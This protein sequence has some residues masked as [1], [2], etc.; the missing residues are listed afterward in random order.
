[1]DNRMGATIGCE[2]KRTSRSAQL[3]VAVWTVAPERCTFSSRSSSDVTSAAANPRSTAS[4][5]VSVRSF[6]SSMTPSTS[7]DSST[8]ASASRG[9]IPRASARARNS[10]RMALTIFSEAF[11]P[12]P[13][14]G[15]AAPIDDTGPMNTES[16]ASAI[17]A[18][19]LHAWALTNAYTG[20]V[21]WET[22]FTICCAASTRPP[23]VSSSRMTARAPAS[24]ASRMARAIN[25]ASPS[26]MTPVTGTRYTVSCCADAGLGP[27]TAPHTT[28]PRIVRRIISPSMASSFPP[29][30]TKRKTGRSTRERTG[31]VTSRSK[32]IDSGWSADSC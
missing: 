14:T 23:G 16:A 5:P 12:A 6:P 10:P 27:S 11:C 19:A 17:I 24:S 13:I 9:S 28:T 2:R 1:M 21:L 8:I 26:S 30:V 25:G 4:F 3:I 31:H 18:P 20:M 15:V 22:A 7:T 29:A 32:Y